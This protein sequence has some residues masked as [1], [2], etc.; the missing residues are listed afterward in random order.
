MYE[1]YTP[2]IFPQREI[3]ITERDFQQ[4]TTSPSTCGRLALGNVFISILRLN[5]VLSKRAIPVPFHPRGRE[6]NKRRGK[7]A[8]MVRARPDT[9][10]RRERNY[11]SHTGRVQQHGVQDLDKQILARNVAAG[12]RSSGSR[13]DH[14][15]GSTAWQWK[16]EKRE[17]K[18]EKRSR[19]AWGRGIKA[20]VYSRRWMLPS[21]FIGRTAME[22]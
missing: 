2:Q 13:K 15:V 20:A 4:Q 5:N 7:V 17:K 3:S 9:T 12:S 21:F 14:Q 16:N 8:E 1:K 11:L 19:S 18:K 6:E 22:N 10:G